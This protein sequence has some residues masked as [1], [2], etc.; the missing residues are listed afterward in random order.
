MKKTFTTISAF[1]LIA[2]FSLLQF[3]ANSIPGKSGW[4]LL[5]TRK[6]NYRLDKDVIMVTSSEGT[7]RQV[8]V[9]VTG[10]SINMHK[11][12]IEYGNGS[13]QN[14]ALKQTFNRGHNSRIIDLNGSKRVI[15]K[16][17]FWYDTKNYSG[18]RANL[19]VFGR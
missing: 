14:V 11:M 4:D 12:L 5:G 7:F 10:G 15:K 18:K 17:T 6:V 19:L 16:I 8:K 1:A 2:F 3:D 13:K 9:K